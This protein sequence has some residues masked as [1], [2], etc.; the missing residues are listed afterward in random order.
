M[1]EVIKKLKEVKKKKYRMTKQRRI[2]LEELK[3]VSSHPSADEIFHL[4]RMKIPNISFGTVYRNLRILKKQGF[5]MELDYGKT[6]S[7]FDG[8]PQN[9]YHFKCIQCGKIFDVKEPVNRSL[10]RRISQEMG[11]QVSCHRLEFY[12]KCKE[13]Q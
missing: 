3:K 13:C 9:H 12:G 6:F 7:R 4:V 5:L 2:I 10:D 8:N 11:F 1:N